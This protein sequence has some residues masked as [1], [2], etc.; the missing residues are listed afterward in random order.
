[1]ILNVPS[2]DDEFLLFVAY[3]IENVLPRSS[4]DE[5]ARVAVKTITGVVLILSGI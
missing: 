1:M 3:L 4:Y 2:T 5:H